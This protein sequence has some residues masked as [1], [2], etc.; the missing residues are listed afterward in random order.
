M[1]KAV[2][3]CCMLCFVRPEFILLLYEDLALNEHYLTVL[4]IHHN[5]VKVNTPPAI[6]R[7]GIDTEFC[8]CGN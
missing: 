2:H 6:V 4:S 3:N 8:I 5:Y 7:R 1:D